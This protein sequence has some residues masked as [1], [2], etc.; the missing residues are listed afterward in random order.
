MKKITIFL[1]I[2]VLMFSNTPAVF[3]QDNVAVSLSVQIAQHI[4]E[5]LRAL[6]QLFLRSKEAAREAKEKLNNFKDLL[7]IAEDI[8]QNNEDRL[9]STQQ[10]LKDRLSGAQEMNE[11]ILARQKDQ[12]RTLQ[13][14]LRDA[15]RK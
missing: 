9:K 14:R 10:L 15:R 6:N 1:F 4:R 2:A 8:K 3:A 7:L 13:D 11:N 12:Q 5:S